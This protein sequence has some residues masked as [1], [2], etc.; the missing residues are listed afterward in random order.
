[1]L[2]TKSLCFAGTATARSQTCLVS[3]M[4]GRAF[5]LRCI[6]VRFPIG[7]QNNL[8]IE[9]WVSPDDEAPTSGDPTG[10]NVLQDY[11]QAAYL[12]GDGDQVVLVHSLRCPDAGNYV[13][14]IGTNDDYYDHAIDVDVEIEVEA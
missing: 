14:V 8:A 6:T 5:V 3:R 9:V 10:V 4:I 12:R 13:K 2:E 7:T 11:S 1:M